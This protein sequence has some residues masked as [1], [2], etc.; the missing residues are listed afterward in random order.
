[1]YIC[2]KVETGDLFKVIKSVNCWCG[3]LKRFVRLQKGEII[4]VRYFSPVNFRCVD[5]VYLCLPENSFL[6]YVTFFGK[7]NE[8]TRFF[9]KKTLR[10]I[11][12]EKLYDVII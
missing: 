5:N 1:M 2:S 10:E 9:N 8:N 4:E 11:L 3:S 6:N 12:D 7:V